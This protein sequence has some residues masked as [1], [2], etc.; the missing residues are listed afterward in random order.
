MS[1]KMGLCSGMELSLRS[2]EEVAIP[3]GVR[4]LYASNGIIVWHLVVVGAK[5][6]R[7][8]A[9]GGLVNE[10]NHCLWCAV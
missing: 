5:R 9:F 8:F 10:E 2:C 3:D 7:C 4:E 1:Q 6:Q